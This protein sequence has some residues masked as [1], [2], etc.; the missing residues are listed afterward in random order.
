[1]PWDVK[2]IFRRYFTRES[3]S[4][5]QRIKCLEEDVEDLQR[6]VRELEDARKDDK[7]DDLN[8]IR[9]S[10]IVL[11]KHPLKGWV[12][13]CVMEKCCGAAFVTIAG[14]ECIWTDKVRKI[15]K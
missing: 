13:G 6:R 9:A 14:G 12:K 8:Y 3:L 5:K 1:M 4:D 15:E 11:V 7:C 2:E 10:D